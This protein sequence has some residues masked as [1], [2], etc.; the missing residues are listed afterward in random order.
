MRRQSRPVER[1][2][3]G[4]MRFP[5]FSR[6]FSPTK[7]LNETLWVDEEEDIIKSTSC[8]FDNVSASKS[9][10]SDTQMLEEEARVTLD[11]IQ[12]LQRRLQV[13][14][15]QKKNKT[16]VRA[17]RKSAPPKPEDKSRT[18][19][20]R[21]RPVK[22]FEP[23]KRT[24]EKRRHQRSQSSNCDRESK[25]LSR[26]TFAESSTLRT[27]EVPPVSE[28]SSFDALTTGICCYWFKTMGNT[29]QKVAPNNGSQQEQQVPLALSLSEE[30]ITIP[31]K[32][33][34]NDSASKKKGYSEQSLRLNPCLRQIRIE[35]KYDSAKG[36]SPTTCLS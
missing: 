18:S 7:D 35:S 5:S 17:P 28:A 20:Q 22:I 14:K 12:S 34:A 9:T 25:H 36:D 27:F 33:T 10:S 15:T 19:P 6:Q 26:V 4:P 2:S 13:L 21:Q 24:P 31:T 3:R 8:S 32:G 16:K 11:A 1:R 30:E 29:L 23:T